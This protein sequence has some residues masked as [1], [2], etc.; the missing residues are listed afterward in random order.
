M[1]IMITIIL[2]RHLEL[3]YQYNLQIKYFLAECLKRPALRAHGWGGGSKRSPL[4]KI[5]HT[6]PTMMKLGTVIPY[7]K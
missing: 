3:T 1:I 2:V 6:Y 4:P 7:P 5:Y